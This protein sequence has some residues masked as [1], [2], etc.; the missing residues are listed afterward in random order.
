MEHLHRVK[1][2]I[3]VVLCVVAGWPMSSYAED[4]RPVVEVDPQPLAAALNSFSEQ[5]GIQ[6]AYV[7]TVADGIESPGTSGEAYPAEALDLMLAE[8][9]LTYS[10]IN[11]T[12]I[13]I[14]AA[15][16]L[17]GGYMGGDSDSK[18]S[19]SMPVLTA[20]KTSQVTPNTTTNSRS[21]EDGMSVVTGKVT[22]ARTGANLK[23]AKV[24]IEETGQWT[25]TNDL[26]EFRFVDVPIG[27]ATLTV[28][29][30]GYAGQSAVVSLR[31][32]TASQNFALRGGSEIE[33]IVV[34]GQRSAR[35][36]ALNQER[37]SENTTSIVSEDMLGNFIGTTLSDS[38]R[39]VAGVAFQRD[40][41]TGDGTNIIVRGLD[42][43]LNQVLLN[44]SALPDGSGAGRS[45][46][47]SNVLAD[48]V[49]SIRISKT[50]LP[51]QEST[52]IGGLVEV[53]TK[54]PLDRARRYLRVGLETVRRDSAFGEDA[55]A[56]A[57]G[58]MTFG[59][60]NNFGLS[61]SVQYREQDVTNISYDL[62]LEYGQYLPLEQDGVTPITDINNVDPSI[63]FPFEEGVDDAIIRDQSNNIS[64]TESSTLTT[65]LSGAWRIS[66]HS[67][68]RLDYLRS[69]R[70]TDQFQRSYFIQPLALYSPTPIPELGGQT[71]GA[72]SLLENPFGSNFLNIRQTYTS[73]VDQ[74]TVTD[75]INL[76]GETQVGKWSFE[77]AAGYVSGETE[78][79]YIGDATFLNASLFFG[80][81]I[82]DLLTPEALNTATG[83]PISIYAPRSGSGYPV[84][85]FNND[86]W[87]LVNSEDDIVFQNGTAVSFTGQNDRESLDLSAK[88][89]FSDTGL[90]YIELGFEVEK[91]RFETDQG[92]IVGY[93]AILD[94]GGDPFFG[95]LPAS[96]FGLT[97][98]DLPLGEISASDNGFALLDE[99]SA[100]TFLNDLGGFAENNPTRLTTSVFSPSALLNQ[101]F[102]E[103]TETVGYFQVRFDRGPWEFIGGIR[104]SNVDVAANF[105][106]TPSLFEN[107]VED[108]SF[109]IANTQVVEESASRTEVLPRFLVNFRPRPNA[110]G[111]FGYF[112][113]VARP[114]IRQ[115]TS[116][117]FVT[118]ILDPTSG[119]NLDRPSLTVS[120][121][122]PALKPAYSHN[123]DLGA[124]LYFE[125]I[126]VLKV[127][128]F[129]KRIENLLQQNALDAV[130][131]VDG[132]ILPDDPRF[133]N[134][135]ADIYISGTQPAN[136]P[137]DSE[138]Y[139]VEL[140]FEKQ[141]TSLPGWLSGLGIYSNY[142]YTDSAIDQT[143]TWTNSPVY[144]SSGVLIGRETVE[145]PAEVRFLQQPRHTGTVGATFNRAAL[146]ASLLYS[147]QSERLSSYGLV[148]SNPNLSLSAFDDSIDSLDFRAAYFLE[149]NVGQFQVYAE[150]IDILKSA[151]DAD[152]Q[153]FRGGVGNTPEYYVGGHFR[154][155]R[156]LVVGVNA[157]F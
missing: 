10:F 146:E 28:S 63:S 54:S 55:L 149:N 143:F 47:L 107:G 95:L 157:T 152:V 8:T 125:D 100:R 30:L 6:F 27:S 61:A 71:R 104:I 111:R 114:E 116:S 112:A 2:V 85:L 141:F 51:N 83:R 123:F 72:L 121:G 133:Q 82:R 131:A 67:S 113:S 142:T 97:F 39:R 89:D 69:D 98:G 128:V 58:S 20:Q 132:V 3:A 14:V 23:G 153:R 52:G 16:G 134:L 34:F 87:A 99:G 21:E 59:R 102:T 41:N 50:L 150:F 36:L 96:A 110:V 79:P 84:P 148:P 11:D 1:A 26:G 147:F 56:S 4:A 129:Y 101:T 151:E 42:P 108:L 65:T 77:Y 92:N 90:R 29:Y 140:A 37:T 76:R 40:A 64:R 138:I 117:Q 9:G 12:T 93:D 46:N 49:S 15:D 106:T 156:S 127:G 73:T 136:N 105:V 38:L 66:N 119:P 35:A 137:R 24:T 78:S 18:N 94:F 53:E 74:E 120:K 145:R 144:D 80:A 130:E 88:Y 60:E 118:L 126:G 103:E 115:L 48:S 70:L 62:G 139:G 135:P 13:V 124:E 86:G 57:T 7:S 109:R 91:S 44:G 33:E 22:D 32:E 25:S 81:V 31:S 122:N 75:S 19:Q 68:L 43:D 154:G 155:G 45:A 5:T 17:D